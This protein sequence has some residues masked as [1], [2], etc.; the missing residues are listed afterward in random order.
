VIRFTLGTKR[1]IRYFGD[2][3]PVAHT[4]PLHYF[5]FWQW[6]GMGACPMLAPRR[7]WVMDFRYNR[8]CSLALGYLGIAYVLEWH[9]VNV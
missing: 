8:H 7:F 3:L 9:G 1:L 6:Y 5:S 4:S 2:M